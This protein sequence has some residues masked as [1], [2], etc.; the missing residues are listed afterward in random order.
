MKKNLL[1]TVVALSVSTPSY[2]GSEIET[3]IDMLH[4]NGLVSDA[5]YG[6]LQDE[7]KLNQAETEKL[8]SR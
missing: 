7:I 6:R 2:A 4:E 3:L 8:N 1:A 5:Q